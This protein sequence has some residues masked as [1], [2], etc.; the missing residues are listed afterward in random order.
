MIHPQWLPE[1][2]PVNPWQ[3]ETYEG[4]YRLFE[5]DFKESQPAYDGQ[6]VWFF[7]GDGG[8]QGKDLLAPDIAG[9]QGDG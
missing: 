4:L 2:F 3:H 1:L 9:E 8:R 5:R 6:T 7:P